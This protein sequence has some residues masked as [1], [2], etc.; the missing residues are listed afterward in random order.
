MF[1]INCKMVEVILSA[2]S[3]FP[4]NFQVQ[5]NAI[6]ALSN[7][8]KFEENIAVLHTE[9]ARMEIVLNKTM[10]RFPECQRK[11]KEVLEVLVAV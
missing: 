5:N 9:H 1:D 11:C 3:G 6:I 8:S 10:A 2:M 7:M 4:R